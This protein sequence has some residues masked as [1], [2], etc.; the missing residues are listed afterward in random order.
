M[1]KQYGDQLQFNKSSRQNVSELVSSADATLTDL[2]KD[3]HVKTTRVAS[4]ESTDAETSDASEY[5]YFQPEENVFDIARDRELYHSA[6]YLKDAISGTG[7]NKLKHPPTVE[8]LNLQN[9]K[10][11]VPPALFNFI[12]LTAGL[13]DEFPENMNQLVEVSS[14]RKVLSLCQDIM[15][16]QQGRETPKS[17][18]L[19]LTVRH[20]TGSKY[21]MNIL[22]GMGHIPSYDTILCADTGI[23]YQQ[24]KNQS[25]GYIPE[26]FRTGVVTTLVYDNIDFLEETLSGSGT[27][28]Y[29]NGIMFQVE[30]T[31]SS[32]HASALPTTVKKSKKT[33]SPTK[34]D[35]NPF[36]LFKKQGPGQTTVDLTSDSSRHLSSCQHDMAYIFMKSNDDP[37]VLMPGWTGFNIRCNNSLP[38]SVIHFLPIIEASPTDMSTVK[39]VLDSA[40]QNADS[41][42]CEQV[43]VVFDLAIYCKAQMIRWSDPI[44]MSRLVPRLGEFHTAMTFLACIGKRFEQSGLEDILIESSVIAHGSMK[45]VMSGHMYNRSVRAHKLLYESLA[46]LQVAEFI[47]SCAIDSQSTISDAINTLVTDF[48]VNPDSQIQVGLPHSVVEQFSKYVQSRCLSDPTYK[49]WNSYLGMV[50]ILLSFLR[51]TRTGDFQLH[52]ESLRQMLPW[53]FACDRFNYAR[54]VLSSVQ[55]TLHKLRCL[56]IYVYTCIAII[57]HWCV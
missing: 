37:T 11:S 1:T 41:L 19:G 45:G 34:S 23:A 30:D 2:V 47:D 31:S 12:C 18:A 10:E 44:I 53:F 29:T 27:S 17:M 25:Q 56:F 35:I 36:F 21:L 43:F 4:T 49:F 28:H 20:A 52:I 13:V 42:L 24:L 50:S 57:I 26:Q 5:A 46:R 55:P 39:H 38:K 40:V 3:K 6:M 32:V 22:S 51:A 9:A 15:S 7:S 54:Y 16:L 14:S 48:L 8:E 33:F